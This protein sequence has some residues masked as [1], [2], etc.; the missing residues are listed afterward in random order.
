LWDSFLKVRLP[1]VNV[2][3]NDKDYEVELAAPGLKKEDFIV[4]VEVGVIPISAQSKINKEEKHKKYT[5]KEFNY[6]SFDRSFVLP[7]NVSEKDIHA[8]YEDGILKVTLKKLYK[9]K[10]DKKIINL[11]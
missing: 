10:F 8:K 1:G 11:K 5:R 7:D 3:E 9:G 6:H 2:T 4:E